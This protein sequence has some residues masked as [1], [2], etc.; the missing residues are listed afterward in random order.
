M[1]KL[2]AALF[3]VI[4]IASLCVVNISAWQEGE[5]PAEEGW[6]R[7]SIFN[8]SFVELVDMFGD[9]YPMPSFYNSGDHDDSFQFW[10]DAAHLYEERGLNIYNGA[11]VVITFTG[12]GIKLCTCYRNDGGFEVADI[13]A[14]LDGEDVT[15]DL[16]DLVA[17]TNDN[18]EHTPIL[19]FT[20]LENG[21][22]VLML[23]NYSNYYRFSVDYFEITSVSSDEPAETEPAETEPAE[24]EP[25]E[26]EPAATE[27]PETKAPETKAPETKAPETKAPETKATET[28]ADGTEPAAE[29]GDA[30]TE[31]QAETKNPNAL[32]PIIAIAAVIV[33]ASIA[34]I[35]IAVKKKK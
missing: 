22:H 35:V 29:S 12:T 7:Y 3:A 16:V 2:L 31:P 27:A 25:A 26:T 9:T 1:K 6:T 8:V 20:G 28:K 23:T 15:D 10:K 34:A 30:E 13:V 21:E 32:I 4:M 11:Q 5:D 24:T 17:P 14:S 18:T 33:L 19:T